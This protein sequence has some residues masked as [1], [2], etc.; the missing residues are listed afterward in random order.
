ML[1]LKDFSG[2]FVQFL[3]A[4]AIHGAFLAFLAALPFLDR[5]PELDI[6]KRPLALIGWI[7]IMAGILLFTVSAILNRE[8]LD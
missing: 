6:F 5:S 3:G 1:R 7:V 2:A 8:F 4:I